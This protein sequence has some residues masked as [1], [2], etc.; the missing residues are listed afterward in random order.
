MK[1]MK[2]N[3]LLI[4]LTMPLGGCASYLSMKYSEEEVQRS[5]IYASGDQKAIKALSF[6]V[7]AE[8][9][10]RAVKLDGDGVGIGLDVSNLQALTLHPFRQMGA[11]ILDAGMLYGTYMGVSSMNSGNS[12]DSTQSS[13]RDTT[14][15]N[16]NGDGNTVSTGD[17]PTV[18]TGTGE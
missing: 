3:I 9:A 5:R 7:P 16:V 17:K 18:M 8:S 10:I 15:V 14:T 13:G 2:I 1:N 4:M 6:G 11:A 12:G